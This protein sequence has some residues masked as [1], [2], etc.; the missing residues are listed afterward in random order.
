MKGKNTCSSAHNRPGTNTAFARTSDLLSKSAALT[1][2]ILMGKS[3]CNPDMGTAP[4]IEAGVDRKKAS[5]R[6]E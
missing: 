5:C 4:D 6:Q 2:Q 3:M 1:I